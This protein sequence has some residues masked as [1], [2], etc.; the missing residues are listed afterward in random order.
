M[1]KLVVL[2]QSFN[3]VGLSAV[4]AIKAKVSAGG[5]VRLQWVHY[6]GKSKSLG[7]QTD[8]NRRNPGYNRVSQK[9]PKRL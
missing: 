3:Q 6:P 2:R 1:V 4:T 5:S 9:L 7:H 8:Y